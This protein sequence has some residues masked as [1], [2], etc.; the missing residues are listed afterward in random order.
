MEDWGTIELTQINECEDF[1]CL[2]YELYNDNNNFMHN[3]NII[4]TAY[5]TGSL[6]GLRVRETNSM[7][8]RGANKDALFCED[9]FYLLPCLCIKEEEKAVIY[10]HTRE[11]D[12]I[13]LQN[14]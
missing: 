13:I 6:C 11:P 9:S 7:Y 4:L 1:W 8:K 3:K 2:I 10:G 5:K 12:H 14:Y